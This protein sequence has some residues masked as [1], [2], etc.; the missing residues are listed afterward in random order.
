[1]NDLLES[2]RMAQIERRLH[3]IGSIVKGNQQF[4]SDR[5]SDVLD[6]VDELRGEIKELKQI[7]CDARKA[8]R[9]LRDLMGG[10]HD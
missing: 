8:Y 9:E 7:V 4:C 1:M 5:I 10:S 6:Q 3:E 2:R